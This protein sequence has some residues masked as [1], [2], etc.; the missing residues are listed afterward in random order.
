[1]LDNVVYDFI[2]NGATLLVSALLQ[3]VRN[4]II[5][6]L[7]HRQVCN[8]PHYLVCYG[9]YLLSWESLHYPLHY[10]TAILIST[11]LIYLI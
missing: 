3:D 2:N 1:M 10:A 7:M 6:I 4:D 8:Y 5:T 11:K 9:S